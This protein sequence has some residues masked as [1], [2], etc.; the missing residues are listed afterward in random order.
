VRVRASP[1]AMPRSQNIIWLD[2]DLFFFQREL[3]TCGPV[4]VCVCASSDPRPCPAL[5]PSLDSR[6]PP[7]LS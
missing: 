6:L 3:H 2:F 4:K 5:V 7:V 1:P